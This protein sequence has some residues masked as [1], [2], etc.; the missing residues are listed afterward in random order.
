MPMKPR[1][2]TRWNLTP[3][4]AMQLQE[5]LRERVALEDHFGEIRY[6][7]GADMAF[8]PVTDATTCAICAGRIRK[9]AVILSPSLSS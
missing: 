3:R 2:E 7:A 8:D 6:V 9:R 4:E 5:S 1:L